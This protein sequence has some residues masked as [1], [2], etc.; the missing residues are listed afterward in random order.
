M[1]SNR[2]KFKKNKLRYY[3]MILVNSVPV[4]VYGSKY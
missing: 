1:L 3:F 2:K 4:N